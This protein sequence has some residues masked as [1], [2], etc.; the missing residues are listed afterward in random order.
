MKKKN[1]LIAV[2]VIALFAVAYLYKKNK[3]K[4][5]AANVAFNEPSAA[6]AAK[7]SLASSVAAAEDLKNNATV[8][9]DAAVLTMGV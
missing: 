9:A 6:D 3:A 1:I 2:G 8:S 4:K 5:A 7:N